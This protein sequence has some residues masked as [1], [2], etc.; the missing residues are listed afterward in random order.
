MAAGQT[1][2]YIN[3]NDIEPL[4]VSGELVHEVGHGT[5]F[6]L[7]GNWLMAETPVHVPAKVFGRKP[8]RTSK[9][10]GLKWRNGREAARQ[11]GL[12]RVMRTSVVPFGDVL[13]VLPLN[14]AHY[15]A[16]PACQ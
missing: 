9:S 2:L 6:T 14:P 10:C 15:P 4:A 7:N 8:W 1:P 5:G 12:E 16:S 11:I 13:P 3:G